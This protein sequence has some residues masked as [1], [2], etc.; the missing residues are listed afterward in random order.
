VALYA[1]AGLQSIASQLRSLEEHATRRGWLIVMRVRE[2]KRVMDERSE[3]ATVMEAARRGEIDAVLVWRLDRWGQS[4][5]DLV[6]TLDELR[7]VG[8]GFLV[9]EPAID[10]S[11]AQS[12]R[13][14]TLL[15]ALADFERALR[16]ERVVRGFEEGRRA[17]KTFGR[18]P[19]AQAHA[20][21]ARRLFAEGLS[22]TKVGERLGI[23][24]R[25]VARFLE[26]APK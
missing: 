25:S 19:T 14:A 21:E 11:A 2:V 17:G 20:E 26:D 13:M 24:R 9:L 7:D 16:S 5:R 15:A 12:R 10:L 1:R 18:P 3:R 8:A 22:R 23:S 6:L 4:L